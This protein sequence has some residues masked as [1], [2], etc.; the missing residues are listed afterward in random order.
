MRKP[1][2]KR[3]F[4]HKKIGGFLGTVGG[5]IPGPVGGIVRI[6][7]RALRGGGTDFREAKSTPKRDRSLGPPGTI[8]GGGPCVGK[9]FFD[10]VRIE[11]VDTFGR[12]LAQQ[13]PG[14]P[15]NGGSRERVP[16]PDIDPGFVSPAE[17]SVLRGEAVRGAFGMPAMV[18]RVVGNISRNDGSTGP[19]L[20]CDAG[21]VLGRDNLC[22]PREI[23]RR[24]SRF[25]KWRPG[26][27]P[28][29]TGGQ[30]RAIRV[31]RG[32]ITTARDAISG[33]GVSV[34]K[35]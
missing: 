18:P 24:N 14:I 30:R 34:T 15:T 13:P 22:Y 35:K 2:D 20:R 33:L 11:C 5:F 26:V 28:V 27:K 16:L 3:G 17:A 29:L 10:P 23:L 9:S 31:A 19:V 4:V 32:A 1:N 25:R 8:R 6:G 12:R 21:L 7:G